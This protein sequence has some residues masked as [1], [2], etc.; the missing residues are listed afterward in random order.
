M[1]NLTPQIKATLELLIDNDFDVAKQSVIATIKEQCYD[2]VAAPYAGLPEEAREAIEPTILK[3]AN[4][5]A[6][7][8]LPELRDAGVAFLK[9]LT[10]RKKE[11]AK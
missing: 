1:T 3:Q 6:A 7:Q 9:S 5:L 10:A 2:E 11:E 8:R 4:K